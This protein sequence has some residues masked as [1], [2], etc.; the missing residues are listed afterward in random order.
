M[1]LKRGNLVSKNFP[2]IGTIHI[3][4]LHGKGNKTRQ[5]PVGPN[6]VELIKERSFILSSQERIEQEFSRHREELRQL[7]RG[8]AAA[9]YIFFE[10]NNKYSVGHAFRDAVRKTGIKHGTFHDLRKTFAT[11]SLE[12]GLTIESVSGVL[13]HSDISITQRS[14]AEKT[15]MKLV[16][17]SKMLTEI[18]KKPSK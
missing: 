5:I 4:T 9:G 13:G 17:E 14:Y 3:L 2:N 7:Y 11:H 18:K 12:S 1:E 16:L 6:A 15:L 8:R 10:V